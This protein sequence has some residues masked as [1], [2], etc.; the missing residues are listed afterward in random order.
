[1]HDG[2]VTA[3]YFP[4]GFRVSPLR[5][6]QTYHVMGTVHR[7]SADRNASLVSPSYTE[8]T[9]EG[10]LARDFFVEH[11]IPYYYMKVDLKDRIGSL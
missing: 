1:M 10:I 5:R 4:K 11:E 3:F 6:C 8:I 2:C 7:L 9:V